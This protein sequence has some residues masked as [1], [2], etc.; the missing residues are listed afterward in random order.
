MK[1]SDLF[2]KCLE[3]EGVEY[4]F[5]VPGEENLDLLESISNSSIKYVITRHEQGA[6]FMAATYGRLTGKAGVVSTTLGPGALNTLNGLAFAKAAGIPLVLITA[7]NGIRHNRKENDYQ[8]VDIVNVMEPITKWNRSI[9]AATWIPKIVRKAFKAAQSERPGATHIELPEDIAEEEVEDIQP[10]P[11]YKVRRPAPD[12]KAIKQAAEILRNSKSPVILAAGGAMRN[13]V[14]KQLLEFVNKTGTYVIHTP[15]GK[16]AF[17]DSHEKSLYTIGIQAH[18]YVNYALDH[19]DTIITLGYYTQEYYP[20]V[21]NKNK[22]KKI[23]HIDFIDAE[24]DNFYS[25]NI[26]IVGDVS[27]TLWAL[28]EELISS[29]LPKWDT[30]YFGKLKKFLDKKYEEEKNQPGYPLKPQKIVDSLQNALDKDSI[31][32]HDNGM[33]KFW[34]GRLYKCELPNTVLVDNAFATMGGGVPG[35]IVAKMINPDKKVVS[36]V[37]DG[38]F[39]MSGMEFE[40]AVRENL[41]VVFLVWVD[42]SYGM[43]KWHQEKSGG[44]FKT[45]GVD[46]KNPDFVKFAESFGGIGYHVDKDSDLEEILN[47]AFTHKD[48]PVIISVPVDYSENLKVLTNELKNKKDPIN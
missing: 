41:N 17:P 36:I 15:M 5:G 26:E 23:I 29:D 19:A 3:N 40:I 39:G 22:D 30:E 9:T 4:I 46:F 44:Q 21:W 20:K 6:A 8:Y 7:Q 18:D 12:P 38:G 28:G 2:V 37:G 13:L 33:H 16:G 45:F 10:L 43:V 31:L 32:V 11:V 25:P 48:K 1:A 24:I 47:K 27:H 14:S 34:I 42:N 35:A